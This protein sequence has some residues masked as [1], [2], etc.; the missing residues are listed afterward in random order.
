MSTDSE[1]ES[2]MGYPIRRNGTC[3]T[4]ETIL[5]PTWGPFQRCCPAYTTSPGGVLP[6]CCPT[7]LDCSSKLRRKARCA[8]HTAVLY[9][10]EETDGN[11]CCADGTR[12]FRK[13][14]NNNVGC[15]KPEYKYALKEV[16]FL[17]PVSQYLLPT[18]TSS[19]TATA[20]PTPTA[21]AVSSTSGTDTNNAKNNTGAIA[22]GVV[23]G[24]GG[25]AILIALVW[26][27][28]RR[29]K[30]QAQASQSTER[31]PVPVSELS[32]ATRITE[33]SDGNRI[34]ELSGQSIPELPG[35]EKPKPPP[36]ELA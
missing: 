16:E 25:V 11:F 10:V 15:V 12:G 31:P 30:K 8:D 4:G 3:V 20:T 1:D 19:N 5:G 27:L 28:L 18:S 21:T 26:L 13:T 32:D 7:Q 6:I 35:S 34:T 24:V 33:L 29:R 2:L 14:A 36:A 22:G 17:P 23:G 9:F